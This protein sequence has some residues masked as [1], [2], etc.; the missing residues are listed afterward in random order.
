M[1]YEEKQH[2]SK[3]GFL[4]NKTPDA[5][6]RTRG[7]AIYKYSQQYGPE[8]KVHLANTGINNKQY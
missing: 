1:C 8:L 3:L 4:Q 6:W 5:K 7:S 2:F